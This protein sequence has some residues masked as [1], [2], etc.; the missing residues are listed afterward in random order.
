MH[1]SLCLCERLKCVNLLNVLSHTGCPRPSLTACFS[2][3]NSRELQMWATCRNKAFSLCSWSFPFLGPWNEI[4]HL[5]RVL[6]MYVSCKA[7]NRHGFAALNIWF[8]SQVIIIVA[9]HP[10]LNIERRPGGLH[11]WNKHHVQMQQSFCLVSCITC[12]GSVCSATAWYLI[13]LKS[14]SFRET[15]WRG[16]PDTRRC[17]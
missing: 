11:I 16:L 13:H 7:W 9:R 2:C 14:V 17:F 1:T 15:W 6:R 10:S 12:S 8:L 3:P 4:L 5:F